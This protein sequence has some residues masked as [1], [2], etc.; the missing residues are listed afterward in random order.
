MDDTPLL[1]RY[2]I[3][4]IDRQLPDDDQGIDDRLAVSDAMLAPMT[5]TQ[6]FVNLA[7]RCGI[8]TDEALVELAQ[9]L[10]PSLTCAVTTKVTADLTEK[11]TQEVTQRIVQILQNVVNNSSPADLAARITYALGVLGEHNDYSV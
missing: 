8:L 11:I 2:R 3:G 5:A 10:T 9:E 7:S 1:P 6:R 4:E